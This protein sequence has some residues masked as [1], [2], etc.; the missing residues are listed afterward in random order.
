MAC[1]LKAGSVMVPRWLP[2]IQPT[3]KVKKECPYLGSLSRIRITLPSKPSMKA[4]GLLGDTEAQEKSNYESTFQASAYIIPANL[5]LPKANSMAKP[6]VKERS[7][8]CSCDGA[9][10]RV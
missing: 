6:K 1:L 5:L 8:T 10:T 9:R 7:S 2:Q 3:M 4:Q